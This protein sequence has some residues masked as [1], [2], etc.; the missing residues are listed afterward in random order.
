MYRVRQRL[1]HVDARPEVFPR[2][3]VDRG[4]VVRAH[5]AKV[6]RVFAGRG[7]GISGRVGNDGVR[8]R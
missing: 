1:R 2:Q 7:A 6:H 3:A 8:I 4:D 5:V